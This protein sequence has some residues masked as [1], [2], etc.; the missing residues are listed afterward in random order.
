LAVKAQMPDAE[1][2]EVPDFAR[3]PNIVAR[4]EMEHAEIPRGVT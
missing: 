1:A 3:R 4:P 2:R